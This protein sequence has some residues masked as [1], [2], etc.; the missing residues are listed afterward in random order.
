MAPVLQVEKNFASLLLRHVSLIPDT[1]AI[2]IPTQWNQESVLQYE[3]LTYKEFGWRVAA[4]QAGLKQA[5]YKAGDRIVVLFPPSLDLYCLVTAMIASGLVPVFIDPGMGM[6][7]I[8]MA[9]EDAKAKAIV[10]VSKFLKLKPLLKSLWGLKS[11]CTDKGDLEQKL[12]VSHNQG[13]SIEPCHEEQHCLIT[14]TSGSTG[15]PKG[16]DR[17]H[18]SLIQQHHALQEHIPNYDYDIPLTS[19]P[20]TVLHGLCCGV[21]TV[22]PAID[23]G[24]PGQV[25]GHLIANQIDEL[26]ATSIGGAPAFMEG[27]A[28]YLL[29][30]GRTLSSVRGVLIGGAAVSPALTQK[31]YEAFPDKEVKIVYGSTESE[32]ISSTSAAEILAAPKAPGLLVGA[33]CS[34]A[35]VAIVK[36]PADTSHIS[37]DDLD[38]YR[39][40][41]GEIGEVVVSGKHVLKRYVDNPAATRENKLPCGDG[42]VWHRTGD[43]AWQDDEAR[44]WLVGR[45]KDTVIHQGRDLHPYL[46]EMDGDAIDGVE[47]CALI[48]AEDS[49]PRTAVMA[50][51]L[52]AGADQHH[53]EQRLQHLFTLQQIQG[54]ELQRVQSIPVDGRHNSKIDRPRLRTQLDKLRR[55]QAPSRHFIVK[56]NRV[57]CLTLS[58]VIAAALSAG[59]AL[60]GEFAYSL[61]LMFVAMLADALDGIWARKRGIER[62]FGRYLDGFV[63]E[64]DY[65]LL[66]SLF[67]YLLGFNDW[68]YVLILLAFV[69]SGM[70]RLAVFNELGNIKEEGSLGYLGMP[71]FWSAFIAGGTYILSWVLP[72][73]VLFPLLAIVLL[74]MTVMMVYRAPFFKF[75]S[76]WQILLLV[77]G[78]AGLFA[79]AGFFGW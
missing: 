39:V 17:T 13:P 19:L 3:T 47:R 70:V 60:K 71:V 65:L 74:G 56:L 79:L 64:L 34:T 5:G 42:S 18:D 26:G 37:G 4:F 66:P 62:A 76:I 45:L 68:Y 52:A 54:V 57:D 31:L 12:F 25:N 55:L 7:R 53:I 50:Y 1:V 2:R 49:S 29:Q 78:G 48:Q 21:Q 40:P 28:D 35:E 72:T 63:D 10:S 67:F 61:S 46:F 27:I 20:V 43:T 6:R 15:R 73:A 69:M 24:K 77:L 22:L 14:F 33:P 75:S 8:M 9:I 36:L 23:L 41:Q 32:P 58:G 38:S 11:Y 16:A 51:Q 44:I 59:L 30:S